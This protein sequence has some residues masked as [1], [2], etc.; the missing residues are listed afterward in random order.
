LWI[1]GQLDILLNSETP[2]KHFEHGVLQFEY[3]AFEEG[4]GKTF[5]QTG[6]LRHP[7]K[8][9]CSIGQIK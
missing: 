4:H 7:E 5:I 3:F 6:R 1:A 8:Y 2:P 9:C